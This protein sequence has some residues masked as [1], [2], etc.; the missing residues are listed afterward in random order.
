[1]KA[2]FLILMLLAAGAA[3]GGDKKNRQSADGGY[4]SSM[5]TNSYNRSE[6][7]REERQPRYNPSVTPDSIQPRQQR[8]Y[9]KP[10]QEAPPKQPAPRI[11]EV[12]PKKDKAVRPSVDPN[13]VKERPPT[14]SAAETRATKK[15]YE[16][17]TPTGVVRERMEREKDGERTQRFNATGRK[18][19]EQIAKADG[20]LQKKFY[21]PTGK[22]AREEI[23]R[24]DGS[25]EV[26]SHQLGRD[27]KV[28]AKETVQYNSQQK[29]VSKTVEK[30]VTINKTINKTVVVH[31]YDSCRYGY[32]YRPVC[33]PAI[34]VS[35]YDPY[36]WGPTGVWIYRPYR[37]TWGWSSF[38]WY[39]CYHGH[40]WSTY[41]VY[42]AP[43]YWA[44]DWV[45][46]SYLADRYDAQ[47]TADQARIEARRARDEAEEARRLAQEAKDQAEAAEA[48]TAQLEAELRAKNAEAKAARLEK[49]ETQR[50]SGQVNPNA[51][52]IDS[53]T[54][55]ALKDQIEKTVADKKAYADAVAKGDNPP[56]PDLAK[57]LANPKHI[58]PVSKTISVVSAKDSNPAGTLTEGDLLKVEPGQDDAIKNATEN[59]L[60]TAR[61]MTSKGEDGEVR[62]GTLVLVSV[63]DLQDF[64]NEFRAKLDQ[65]LEE[66]DK[67]KDAFKEGAVKK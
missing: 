30:T 18:E 48:R 35:W 16:T 13:P 11:I 23:Q 17:R 66:A 32:V 9:E 61:V 1:M 19:Q 15:G 10:R 50:K 25:R 22:V 28:R 56:L 62:A 33:R 3:Q 65:A 38:G 58:F 64:E 67:N 36:W 6:R 37:Y 7:E 40:Y 52:P 41:E 63:R 29:A 47:I 5:A 53:S 26:T 46:A 55:E 42:P 45:M 8:T 4:S 51:T 12:E 14:A 59:T 2:R 21:T 57:A 34:Y 31:H 54:K 49:D 39:H 20:S 27:G 44:T 24:A 60:L 43:S